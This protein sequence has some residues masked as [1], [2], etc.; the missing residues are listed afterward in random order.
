MIKFTVLLFRVLPNEAH[1]SFFERVTKEIAKAGPSVQSTLGPLV[2]EL[3][4]WFTKETA[5]VEWYSKSNLTA[6]IAGADRRLDSVLAGFSAQLKGA[7]YSALPAVSTAA[8]RLHIMLKSYGRVARK[9]Y[10]QEIGAVKAV[11]EHLNGDLLHDVQAAGMTEWTV[12][13]QSS[14]N[15][16]VLLMEQREEQ[17]LR[18]PQQGF[19]EVRRGIEDVWRRIV[20]LIDAGATLN[21]SPDYAALINALN[22]EIEYLNRE[23]RYV[24][25]SIA[26]AEPSPIE[27]QQY[28][29]QPCTPVPDVFC[30]TSKGM[31]KLILGKDFNITFKNNIN[32][33]NAECTIHGKGKFKGQKT[34]TFV[35]LNFEF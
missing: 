1:Y 6:A 30:Q 15:S 29:G 31:V 3:N 32:V 16:F 9:P 27:Q 24:R 17:T 10:L 20:K 5:C 4:D 23:F 14:L 34:V 8:E 11:L 28:T 13:I 22:P 26:D 18:K 35:I 2:A 12:E 7:L 33:G 21:I 25:H 19:P